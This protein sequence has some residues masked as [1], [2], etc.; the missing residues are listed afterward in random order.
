MAITKVGDPDDSLLVGSSNVMRRVRDQL[1]SLA[2]VP[3]PVRIEGPTGTGKGNAARFLHLQ[4]PRHSAP[5][6]A[7]NINMLSTGL[8]VAELTGF[9]RGAF[10]GAVT[11]S[12]GAFERAHNGTLFLD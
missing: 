11:D 8:E 1:R 10:T 4:S 3:W 9:V 2:D 5:F 12:A 7:C 6:V